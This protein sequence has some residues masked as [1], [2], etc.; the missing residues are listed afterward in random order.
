MTNMQIAGLLGP[1]LPTASPLPWSAAPESGHLLKASKIFP[2]S[3]A[4]STP[5]GRS[6]LNGL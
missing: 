5:I 4:L 3:L 2:L 6:Y 1:V